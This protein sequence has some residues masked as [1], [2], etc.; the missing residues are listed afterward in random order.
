MAKHRVFMVP[1]W[2]SDDEP[3]SKDYVEVASGPHT[4]T[5]PVSTFLEHLTDAQ[6]RKIALISF[7]NGTTVREEL[8]YVLSMT[9]EPGDKAGTLTMAFRGV[10]GPGVMLPDGSTHT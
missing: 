6:W 10:P 8:R 3:L 2:A 1:K 5:V 4:W 9:I 7:Y